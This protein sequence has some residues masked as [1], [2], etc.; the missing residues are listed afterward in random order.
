MAQSLD[1][2]LPVGQDTR[3]LS[4]ASSNADVPVALGPAG[5]LGLRRAAEI[6]EGA[7]YDLASCQSAQ[8][9]SRLIEI[10]AE[11]DRLAREG[12]ADAPSGHPQV[13]ALVRD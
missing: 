11:L 13:L 1:H 2:S 12:S 8:H 10:A 7:A 9:T 4:L 6:V 5:K 3:Q